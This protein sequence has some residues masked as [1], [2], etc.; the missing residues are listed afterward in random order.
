MDYDFKSVEKK[1]QN[2]WEEK[3]VFHAKNK[4]HV[5][6]SCR[7]GIYISVSRKSQKTQSSAKDNP[8]SVAPYNRRSRKNL[9][10]SPATLSG[11][12]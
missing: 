8:K 12:K 7:Y 10:L 9:F 11:N 6:K 5:Y 2:I 4:K 3:G 1:W